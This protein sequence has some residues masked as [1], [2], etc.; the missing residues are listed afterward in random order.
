MR[1]RFLGAARAVTGSCHMIETDNGNL[2]VDCGMHQGRDQH[3]WNPLAPFGFNPPEIKCVL[4]THSHID[5]SGLIPLLVKNGFTGKVYCT[6]PTADLCSIML[7]DSGYIQ[8]MEAEQ[9]NRKRLRAGK[10]PVEPL[11]TAADADACLGSFARLDYGETAEVLPGVRARFGEAGHLLGSSTVELWVEDAHGDAK[12]VFSGD[13]GTYNRP[14]INDPGVITEADYV[15]MESTYGDR[16]HDMHCDAKKQFREIVRSAIAKG[17]NLV[18]PSFAVGRTQELLY[19]LKIMML[20]GDV[21]GLDKVPIYV[22]SPLATRATEIFRKDYY[23][24]Y[25]PETMALMARGED[26]LNMPNLQFSETTDQSRAINEAEG[27]NIIISASGMCEAG[28]IRHHL[29]HNLWREEA[30]VLFVGYQAENTLGRLLLD[31]ARSVK[32]FGEEI[33]VRARICNIPGYSG[34]ADRDGLIEWIK[35]FD[36]KPRKV[37]VVH[38]ESAVCDV[39]AKALRDRLGLDAAVPDEGMCYDIAMEAW[40]GGRAPKVPAEETLLRMEGAL[41]DLIRDGSRAIREGG[42]KAVSAQQMQ[43]ELERFLGRWMGRIA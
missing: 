39:F 29:K 23:K 26:P 6:G 7:P 14:I 27:T 12:L 4:L 31:G 34:H 28:R 2:L 43:E 35:A 11:Y 5:H 41:R 22:D 37:F 3:D 17:G 18:I 38:G 19:D 42:E 20:G 16:L 1:I 21:P 8:E 10:Q 24:Y 36:P 40:E 30:T 13:I 25:D 33:F 15:V 9:R 32:I